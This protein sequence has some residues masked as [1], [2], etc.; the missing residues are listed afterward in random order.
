MS[1]PPPGCCVTNRV[2]V[3][4]LRKTTIFFLPKWKAF[5]YYFMC[6]LFIYYYLY[7]DPNNLKLVF[8]S[9]GFPSVT[10]DVARFLTY[11]LAFW[12]CHL[13]LP[14]LHYDY[15]YG[16]K[17]L[18]DGSTSVY[19]GFCTISPSFFSL[20]R[21]RQ[22]ISYLFSAGAAAAFG[23]RLLERKINVGVQD[24]MWTIGY[25]TICWLGSRVEPISTNQ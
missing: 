18:L 4:H 24:N 6:I 22:P 20:Q 5:I 11:L 15:C 19:I 21:T 10:T 1:I 14:S 17:Q 8:P 16:K 2:V 9:S 3:F 7:R 25:P 12:I 23:S 13:L